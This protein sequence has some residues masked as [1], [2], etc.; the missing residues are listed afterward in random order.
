MGGCFRA[1]IRHGAL[2]AANQVLI[3]YQWGSELLSTS[4]T[5]GFGRVSGSG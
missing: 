2:R 1:V 4:G 5:P 3:R